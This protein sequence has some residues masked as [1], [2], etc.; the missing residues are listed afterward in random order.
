MRL[1]YIAF[2][3]SLFI[4][5]SIIWI[6]IIDKLLENMSKISIGFCIPIPIILILWYLLS[7]LIFKTIDKE[8]RR[9]KLDKLNNK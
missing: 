9:I 4:G 8:V 2:L 3:F 5:L 6:N 1:L 7:S